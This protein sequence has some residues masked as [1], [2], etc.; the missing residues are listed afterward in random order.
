MLYLLALS[1]SETQTIWWLYQIDPLRDK[2]I[3][4][5]LLPTAAQ[6][7]TLVPTSAYWFI[8]EKGSVQD[9]GRQKIG[10]LLAIPTNWLVNP[11]SSPLNENHSKA[12]GS[13]L[14]I[15]ADKRKKA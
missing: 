4:R 15:M 10:S 11:I 5:V 3:G 6:H 1:P 2:I 8:F 14:C 13:F 12:S 7:I 9:P